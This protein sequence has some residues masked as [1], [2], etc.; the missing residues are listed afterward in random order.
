MDIVASFEENRQVTSTGLEGVKSGTGSGRRE[1]AVSGGQESQ[2]SH[3]VRGDHYQLMGSDRSLIFHDL[4]F[5]PSC[6]SYLC[7][8]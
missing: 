3:Q 8:W 7:I 5:L 2:S 6:I 4:V 1:E